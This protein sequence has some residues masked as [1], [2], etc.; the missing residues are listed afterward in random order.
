MA[1]ILL[2]GGAGCQVKGSVH[3]L[4]GEDERADSNAHDEVG[5]SSWLPRVT[6]AL[7]FSD[8]ALATDI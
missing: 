2:P 5:R 1:E 4:S 3:V 7:E 6:V 8:K